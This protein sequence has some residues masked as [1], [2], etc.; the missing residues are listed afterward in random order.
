MSPAIG[1][2]IIGHH[3]SGKTTLLQTLVAQGL[4]DTVVVLR[5]PQ[6]LYCEVATVDAEGRVHTRVGLT[7]DAPQPSQGFIFAGI[8][9]QNAPPRPPAADHYDVVLYNPW[10][11]EDAR[12][13]FAAGAT[14]ILEI[15]AQ[16][17]AAREPLS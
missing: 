8:V 5:V 7:A 3:V 15:L 2:A 10:G 17:A 9:R 4:R 12:A 16:R 11:A 13:R 14:Q 1:I 6:A